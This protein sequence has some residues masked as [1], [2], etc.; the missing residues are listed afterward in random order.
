MLPG[1]AV[2]AYVRRGACADPP[3]S[4]PILN[5]SECWRRTFHFLPIGLAPA[6]RWCRTGTG[7][8]CEI[9]RVSNVTVIV[10]VTWIL[11]QHCPRSSP[12]YII[13]LSKK[14][15]RQCLGPVCRSFGM[16]SSWQ[17]VTLVGLTRMIFRR[18][19]GASMHHARHGCIISTH[20]LVSNQSL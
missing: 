1:P 19:G 13:I 7:T 9:C 4:I 14:G 15:C 12:I 20:V 2:H 18:K 8:S 16:Q 5:T 11:T 17:L 3:T 10:L 6:V